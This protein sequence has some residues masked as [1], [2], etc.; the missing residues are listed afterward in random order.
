MVKSG[1]EIA[2]MQ[3]VAT[4]LRSYFDDVDALCMDGVS[5]IEV[6]RSVRQFL[7]RRG[8]Q[9]AL[10]GYRGYPAHCSVSINDVAVHGIPDDRVISRGDV[11]SLDIAASGGGWF[12]DMAWSFLMP[13]ASRRSHDE[14]LRAWGSF[15]DLV[16]S[17]TPDMNLQELARAAEESAARRGLI[18]IAEFT[19]HGIGRSLHESPVVPFCSHALFNSGPGERIRLI[20]GTVINVEPVYRVQSGSGSGI[21]RDENGWS[22]RTTDGSRAYHFELTLA[23]GE[24]G[25]S[26]LQWAGMAAEE[27]SE[28]PPFGIL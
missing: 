25:V 24:R 5:S 22:Y 8:L 13:G 12:T 14:Y 16:R 1:I 9:S 20:P 19:G 17:I 15:V 3:Q 27:L 6:D 10:T 18:P 28:T 7:H 11:V 4:T 26:I 2:R 21:R 23:I